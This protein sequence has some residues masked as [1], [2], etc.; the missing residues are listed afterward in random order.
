M[1]NHHY[2]TSLYPRVE[3]IILSSF[4][5]FLYFGLALS[6]QIYEYMN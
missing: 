3:N 1:I 6:E 2:L 4:Y 5:S